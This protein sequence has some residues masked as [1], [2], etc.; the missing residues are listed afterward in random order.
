MGDIDTLS[1]IAPETTSW[2]NAA[3]SMGGI[4]RRYAVHHMGIFPVP[5]R[6]I[7]ILELIKP[8]GVVVQPKT[9]QD[10]EGRMINVDWRIDHEFSFVLERM[11][12]YCSSQDDIGGIPSM[13]GEVGFIA[14]HDCSIWPAIFFD[15]RL[16][17]DSNC[18]PARVV[19]MYDVET[20]SWDA[21]VALL[22]GYQKGEWV[23][24]S[25][26]EFLPFRQFRSMVEE[27]RAADAGNRAF[28]H[29]ASLFAAA[30]QC[31]DRRYQDQCSLSTP[32]IIHRL[33]WPALALFVY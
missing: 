20:M 9:L 19:K 25:V 1:E 30:M 14:R 32:G 33:L 12:K 4:G 15:P 23:L 5:S 21:R 13:V 6:F 24:T 31:A 7:P 16:E 28:G 17:E 3:F 8:S 2:P 18:V 29:D 26:K 11:K 27:T 10:W 22:L